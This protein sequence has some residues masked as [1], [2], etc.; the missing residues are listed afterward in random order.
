MRYSTRFASLF[1]FG[2]A[3]LAGH[4]VPAHAKVADPSKCSHDPVLVGNTS[5]TS[6]GGY[7]VTVRDV[8]NVPLP[9]CTVTINFATGAARPYDTQEAGTTTDC[10]NGTIARITDGDGSVVFHARI[11]GYDNIAVQVRANGVLIGSTLIRS[12]DID[13]NGV[14]DLGDLSRFRQRFLF[15]TA[16]SE[17][18]FNLD[19]RTD[20]S[21][22]DMLRQEYLKNARGTPC[23]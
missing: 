21:D 2:L 4:P 19:G 22:L 7:H 23:P 11:A 18:D 6:L 3:V 17:T 10:P 20:L 15:D 16:A 1:L 5:G 14:T 9:G 8:G 12:T 13:G